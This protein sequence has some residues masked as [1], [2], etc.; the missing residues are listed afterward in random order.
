[1]KKFLALV[2][3]ISVIFLQ[4]NVIGKNTDSPT[5]RSSNPKQNAI[6]VSTTKALTVTFNETVVKG[7]SFSKIKLINSTGWTFPAAIS[8]SKNVLIVKLKYKLSQL[9]TYYL[10]VPAKAVKDLEGNVLGK[11]YAIKFKTVGKVTPKPTVKPTATPKATPTPTLKPTATPM[12]T[13]TPNSNVTPTPTPSITPAATVSPTPATPSRM[14]V[15]TNFWNKGWGYGW[16]D[17]FNSGVNWSTT[18]DP[19][20]QSFIDDLINAKYSVLRFMDWGETNS[21]SVKTW[22]QRVLKTAN[23]Y[24]SK[25]IAYEC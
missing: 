4:F 14:A 3:V 16:S 17:Y 22:N 2:L 21:S 10:I 9:K 15:G 5:V 24:T 1:M 19:W 13:P 20:K 8:I 6:N 11:S 12:A 25:G 18:T 23:Q 7:P